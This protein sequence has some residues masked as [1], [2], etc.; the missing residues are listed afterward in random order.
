M[1]L[2]HPTSNGRSLKDQDEATSCV[3]SIYFNQVW[4]EGE[5]SHWTEWEFS[6]CPPL[7]RPFCFAYEYSRELESLRHVIDDIRYGKSSD[8]GSYWKPR[9]GF[10][11]FYWPE[12]PFFAV[13]EAERDQMVQ[14]IIEQSRAP[15]LN[16]ETMLSG[17]WIRQIQY[18]QVEQPI[19]AWLPD[20]VPGHKGRSSPMAKYADLLRGLGM[21]R[22]AKERNNLKE[23][24]DFLREHCATM[25]YA[26]QSTLKTAIKPIPRILCA[27]D[28]IANANIRNGYWFPPFGPYILQP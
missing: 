22:L 25:P 4:P 17:G 15:L 2:I 9:P 12:T 16:T 11:G 13:P 7:M 10:G 6:V 21:Y 14:A 24:M 5:S 23:V 27:F 1:K 19:C 18:T 28:L 8:P 20:Q 3:R 26:R